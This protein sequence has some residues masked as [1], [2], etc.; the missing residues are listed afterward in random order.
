MK[1]V[2][3]RV[4]GMTCSECAS[5]VRSALERQSGVHGVQVSLSEGEARMSTDDVVDPSNLLALGREAGFE[6]SIMDVRNIEWV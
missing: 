5:E 3:M 1:L 6:S 4:D 2:S